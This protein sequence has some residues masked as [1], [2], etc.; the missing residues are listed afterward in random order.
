MNKLLWIFHALLTLAMGLFGFQK[1]VGSMPALI[2]QG[3]W[4]IADFPEWQVRAI[5]VLEVLGALGLN[6]PYV[7]K[8]LP[9][10]LVPAAAA[11]LALTMIGAI[12]THIT[13]GDPAP[14]VV[15]TTVLFAMAATL[16]FKRYRALRNPADDDAKGALPHPAGAAP[17][18]QASAE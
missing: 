11:G 7:I 17:S 10:V 16:A 14:S 3:M 13:R 15:I 4:W 2:E 9:R 1:V 12:A 18:L 6:A 5:G 8:K